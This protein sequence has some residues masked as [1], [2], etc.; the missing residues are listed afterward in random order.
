MS[1]DETD[2]ID[3]ASFHSVFHPE[4][5]L[6]PAERRRRVVRLCCSFMRNVAFHRAGMQREVQLN[7]FAPTHPQGAF[8]REA[9]GNFFDI[10]V[11]EWCKLF[12]DRD[13]NGWGKHHWRRVVEN[14]DRF[15]ADLY[16]TPGVTADAF[17][18]LTKKIKDYRDQFVAHL[19]EERTMLLPELEVARR[20]IVFLHQRLA[21]EARSY[22]DWRGLPTTAE[23]LDQGFA[24]ACREAQSVYAEA[25][26]RHRI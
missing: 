25:L 23:Q 8:W 15:E 7:L 2:D 26:A 11:L 4:P 14:P 22:E 3:M 13:R 9:H 21:Q 18:T 5:K 16:A 10:S 20:A 17:T 24:Q 12:A 1:D 6:K 19:D